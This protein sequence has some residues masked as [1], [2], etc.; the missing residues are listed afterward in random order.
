MKGSMPGPQR[1]EE[2]MKMISRAELERVND[3]RLD[4]L[5][6]EIRRD[7]A[8]ADRKIRRDYAALDDVRHARRHRRVM[9]P[10]L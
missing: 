7:I 2:K 1:Q 6:A 9:R 3:R 10:N 5:E 8:C 4:G